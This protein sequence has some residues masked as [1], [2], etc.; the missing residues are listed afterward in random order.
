MSSTLNPQP[1]TTNGSLADVAGFLGVS[2]KTAQRLVTAGALGSWKAGRQRRVSEEDLVAYVVRTKRSAG[3]KAWE[4]A[5]QVRQ[6]WR[7]FLAGNK[8]V[9][10]LNDLI[11]RIERLEAALSGLHHS[12]EA[13]A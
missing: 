6:E 1:S 2:R 10:R 13:A 5:E 3:S 11:S 8:E 9:S 4:S 12:K 7:A